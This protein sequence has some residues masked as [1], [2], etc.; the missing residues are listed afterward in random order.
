M[1]LRYPTLSCD[2]LVG[3]EIAPT[4]VGSARPLLSVMIPTF[5]CAR[6]LEQTIRSVLTQGHANEDMEIVVV[7]DA[8]TKD[9]PE[10]VVRNVASSRIRFERNPVN[11]GAAANFNRCLQLSSGRLVHIL[12]G[13]DFVRSDFYLRIARAFEQYPEIDLVSC[14][15][16]V[17]DESGVVEWITPKIGTEREGRISIE[18]IATSNGISTPSVVVRRS[19]YE[20]HGGFLTELTHVA[21]WEMWCRAAQFG[22]A[23]FINEPLAYYRLFPGNE[24]SRL[25][26]TGR[27]V[28]EYIVLADLL[29]ARGVS[30]EATRQY[31]V[32]A[33]FGQLTRFLA[34]KD[35]DA[36][37]ANVRFYKAYAKNLGLRE[38]ITNQF[39]MLRM[40][41]TISTTLLV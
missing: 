23:L 39:R 27:N 5:N 38:R 26:R 36:Y 28:A 1:H 34:N 35:M 17:V 33:A 12:H 7:D 11:S 32:R 13:D 37:H 20:R 4:G 25:A 31:A 14:R 15:S 21:D 18:Q 2:M 9:D 40:Q 6:F 22:G 41:R 30:V 19:F 10:A 24:T 3:P 29:E 16:F 8:S